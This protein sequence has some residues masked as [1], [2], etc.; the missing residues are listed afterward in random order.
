MYWYN[1]HIGYHVVGVLFL[2]FYAELMKNSMLVY[3]NTMSTCNYKKL[4]KFTLNPGNY[5]PV[6]IMTILTKIVAIMEFWPDAPKSSRFLT[7]Y[8]IILIFYLHVIETISLLLFTITI[9][10]N[11][12]K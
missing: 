9:L 7:D 10:G 5:L 8:D 4:I 3:K 2:L 11:G 1:F 6:R 12:K